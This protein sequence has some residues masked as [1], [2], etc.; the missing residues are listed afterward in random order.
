ME[1]TAEPKDLWNLKIDEEAPEEATSVVQ[2]SGARPSLKR[3]RIPEE[4]I[5][6]LT[7]S[8]SGQWI[9]R[10]A[11]SLLHPTLLMERYDNSKSAQ[12][13]APRARTR[14]FEIHGRS[15]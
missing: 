15:L 7:L 9:S 13:H 5:R 4:K 1:F 10:L 11:E 14:L 12:T 2:H 3:R 6:G 8:L